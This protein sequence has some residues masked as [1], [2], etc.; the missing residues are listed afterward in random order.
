ML[1]LYL[2]KQNHSHELST[3]ELMLRKCPQLV[4]EANNESVSPLFK[5][6]QVFGSKSRWLLQTML[7]HGSVNFDVVDNHGCNVFH[8][9][10]AN[11]QNEQL[12]RSF[13]VA[14]MQQ[15]AANV[16]KIME[17]PNIDGRTP[18]DVAKL[19]KNEAFMDVVEMS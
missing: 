3:V 10:A 17:M 18:I 8:H 2:A 5:T 1:L 12:I 4:N 9:L 6:I 14:Y 11:V 19:N 7:K 16:S 13:I 15:P